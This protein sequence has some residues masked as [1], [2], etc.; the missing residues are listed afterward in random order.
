MKKKERLANKRFFFAISI[1]VLVVDSLLIM[2][3]ATKRLVYKCWKD[4]SLGI[5]FS[6]K[7]KDIIVNININTKIPSGS[8]TLLHFSIRY[9]EQIWLMI[10][11][12]NI[13]LINHDEDQRCPLVEPDAQISLK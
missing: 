11:L 2:K 5:E 1:G 12:D 6:S 9:K 4:N 13:Y 3:K 10:T 8:G 7:T